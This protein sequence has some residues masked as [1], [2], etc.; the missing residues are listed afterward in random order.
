[1][2]YIYDV[3]LNFQEN[4]YQFFEW[5]KHDKIKN[6][7]KIP[8]YHVSDEDI[9]NLKNNKIIIDIQTLAK[10]KTN[11]HHQGKIILLVSNTKMTIG[12]LF[13][14]K[15]EL[16]KRSSLIY[17]EEDEASSLASTLPLT[18]ITYQE[19]NIIYKENKLRIEIEKKEILLKYIKE[20]KDKVL[21]K[22]L[23]YEYFHHEKTNIEEIKQDLLNEVAKNW[24]KKQND[25]YHLAN[26]LNKNFSFSKER[27]N[28]G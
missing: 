25:L 15:G 3:A 8:L 23:Y 16:L 27:T 6:I 2:N 26:L 21:L 5:N 14:E 7:S 10:F 13:N 1:M 11:H 4:Y 12:L 9:I 28:S 20:N 18:E 24:T 17:E 22:Y 19:N